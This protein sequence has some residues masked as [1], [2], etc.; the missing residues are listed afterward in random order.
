VV[1]ER[2]L[3]ILKKLRYQRNLNNLPPRKKNLFQKK[4]KIS[5][6]TLT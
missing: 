1:K 5:N 3:K 2:R 4:M 6:T